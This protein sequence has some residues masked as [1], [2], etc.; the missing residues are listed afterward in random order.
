MHRWM[1]SAAGGTSQRL[2]PALAIV[3][4]L[5]RNPAP[6]PDMVPP[7]LMVVIEPSLQPLFL[8]VSAVYDP[9]LS[10][11]LRISNAAPHNF[12]MRQDR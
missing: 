4:S 3:R 9:V 8:S 5:S 7:L 12:R 2:K 10:P 6:A 1:Q 11:S